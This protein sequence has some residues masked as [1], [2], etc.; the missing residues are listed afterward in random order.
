MFS[1]FFVAEQLGKTM[2]EIIDVSV[3]EFMHW[4]AYFKIQNE[5]HK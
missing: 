3:S 5:K 1:R 2:D 4:L